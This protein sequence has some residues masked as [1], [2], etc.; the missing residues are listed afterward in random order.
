MAWIIGNSYPYQDSL[1]KQ[2]DVFEEPFPVSIFVQ[3]TGEYPRYSWENLIDIITE[4]YPEG[5]YIQKDSDYPKYLNLQLMDMGTCCW[6]TNLSKAVLPNSVKSIGVT[7]FRYTSLKEITLP[8]DCTYY[9]T[10][11][12][13]DCSVIGGLLIT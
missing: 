4:P 2:I 11:F 8:Y 1:G 5:L 6:A 10:S 3:P 7:A 9:K 12:P 13:D